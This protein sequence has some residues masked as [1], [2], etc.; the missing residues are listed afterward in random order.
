MELRHLRYFVAVGEEEHFGRAAERL[1]VVQPAL[2]RQVRQLEEELG[3]FDR[4]KWGVRLTEAGKSFLDE[5][6]RLLSDLERGVDRTRLVA[7][8]KIGRLRVGFSET[9]TH[10]GEELPSILR[11][12]RAGWPDVRLELFPSTSISAVDQLR[13]RELD[14]AFVY[15][16]P[17]NPRELGSHTISVERVVLALPQAHP[18]VTRKRVSLR[19]LREESFVVPPRTAATLVYDRVLSACH[20]AGVTF[21]IVQEVKSYATMLNLVAGGIGLSF[22]TES[23]ERTK[24]NGVV[25]RDVADLRV[26][27][28]LFAIWRKDN[29]APALQKFVEMIRSQF[30]DVA[31][32]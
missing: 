28:E 8:G 26:T 21:K 16:P 12:F 32:N 10:G 25:L 2:T 17:S 7:Q 31:R 13:N 18:L 11:H 6:R 22:V 9:A 24:P 29:K 23:A 3:L 15:I 4:L 27:A 30:A 19:D 20:T 5:A 14:A 1:H